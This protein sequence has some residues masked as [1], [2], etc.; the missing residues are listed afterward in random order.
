[1]IW[2]YLDDERGAPARD[3]ILIPDY[4]SM[5][6]AIIMCHRYHIPF[7]IDFDYDI[8]DP[9]QSGYEV[10]SYICNRGI[11]MEAFHIH[12]SNKEGASRIREVLTINGYR[13]TL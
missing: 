9:Y 6:N 1:M 3:M 12:S 4:Q 2:F 7:G 10:A 13:E 8:G 11:E 5:I